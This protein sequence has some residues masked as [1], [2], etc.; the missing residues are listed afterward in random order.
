M[1]APTLCRWGRNQRIAIHS[2]TCLLY[3]NITVDFF[4]LTYLVSYFSNWYET[5]VREGSMYVSVGKQAWQAVTLEWYWKKFL[6]VNQKVRP[7]RL[8]NAVFDFSISNCSWKADQGIWIPYLFEV[9]KLIWYLL[10]PLTP[11]RWWKPYSDP[12]FILAWSLQV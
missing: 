4:P 11:D 9:L 6:V 7:E 5:Q 1:A 12:V 10:L 3:V 2:V 8:L